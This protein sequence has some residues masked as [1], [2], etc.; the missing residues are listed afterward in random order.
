MLKFTKKEAESVARVGALIDPHEPHKVVILAR[1]SAYGAG[2]LM[3]CR[4]EGNGI[5]RRAALLSCRESRG[6]R[7]VHEVVNMAAGHKNPL[8]VMTGDFSEYMA[9]SLRH[10]YA[11]PSVQIYKPGMACT[12]ITAQGVYFNQKA[13]CAHTAAIAAKGGRVSF[14]GMPADIRAALQQQLRQLEFRSTRGGRIAVENA[15]GKKLSLLSVVFGE[16]LRL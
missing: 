3:A 13:F 1:S 11:I 12:G 2:L 6:P 15:G 10:T 5:E 4:V 7:F 9:D 16:N 14:H 8:L